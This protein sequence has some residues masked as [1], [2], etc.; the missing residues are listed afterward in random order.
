M[1][2]SRRPILTGKFKS[3]LITCQLTGVPN[4]GLLHVR[5]YDEPK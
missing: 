5:K 4:Q 2:R 3:F 1:Q